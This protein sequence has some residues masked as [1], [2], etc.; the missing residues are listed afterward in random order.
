MVGEEVLGKGRILGVLW[1]ENSRRCCGTAWRHR[2]SRPRWLSSGWMA[3][4]RRSVWLG[5]RGD[6]WV[7]H[8]YS[9]VL[10]Q[11]LYIS[12]MSPFHP[13]FKTT[14]TL[15]S[16]KWNFLRVILLSANLWQNPTAYWVNSGLLCL[17]V[18]IF[19][20]DL[21][22][23]LSAPHFSVLLIHSAWE[24]RVYSIKRQMNKNICVHSLPYLKVTLKLTFLMKIFPS[25]WLCHFFYSILPPSG[26]WIR[27]E[28]P[29]EIKP[30]CEA[31]VAICGVNTPSVEDCQP[32]TCPRIWSWEGLYTITTMWSG[33]SQSQHITAPTV[34]TVHTIDSH[35]LQ[36]DFYCRYL[37]TNLPLLDCRYVEGKNFI[38]YNGG[39]HQLNSLG[40]SK[41]KMEGQTQTT[42]SHS[43]MPEWSVSLPNFSVHRSEWE[44]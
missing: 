30:W 34:H 38:I 28:A 40:A 19:H 24:I 3:E 16:L 37:Y 4:R 17:E 7:H 2:A 43:S 35:S 33:R 8:V 14:N 11:T 42:K 44:N 15:S 1:G 20:N 12:E 18:K 9:R 23:W 22:P 10:C 13:H 29:W 6:G 32:P 39:Y 5:L 21:S 41:F 36:S 31:H 25:F 27:M 26:K